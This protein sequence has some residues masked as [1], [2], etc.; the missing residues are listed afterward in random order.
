[1]LEPYVMKVTRTCSLGEEERATSLTYP[2]QFLIIYFK[3]SE[4]LYIY[5]IDFFL[6][7]D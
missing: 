2:T 1:M 4:I 5:S 7:Y 6:Y 3:I